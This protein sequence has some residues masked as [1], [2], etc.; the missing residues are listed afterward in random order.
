MFVFPTPHVAQNSNT[1]P[2]AES[3]EAK[4]KERLGGEANDR[5]REAGEQFG[6]GQE[7]VPQMLG[8]PNQDRHAGE[9]TARRAAA[10]GTNRQYMHDL[11][12]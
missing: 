7:K 10:A 5:Q 4:L 11:E 9:T 1:S 12:L 6:R 2:V 8:E 3:Y